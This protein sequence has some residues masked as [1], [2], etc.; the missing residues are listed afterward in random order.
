MVY[1]FW[2]IIYLFSKFIENH[3][4]N[5]NLFIPQSKSKHCFYIKFYA[6][7]CY[8]SSESN[9]TLFFLYFFI[10]GFISYIYLIP[11]I[12]IYIFYYFIS[13]IFDNWLN[14]NKPPFS[15]FYSLIGW[16]AYI[17]GGGRGIIICAEEEAILFGIIG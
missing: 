10:Y 13:E 4:F 15:T 3:S 11:D 8:S 14:E 5:F 12:Y 16:I 1:F 2:I 9:S 7:Y 17:G 6:N